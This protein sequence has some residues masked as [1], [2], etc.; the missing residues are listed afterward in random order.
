MI[1]VAWLAVR[2]DWSPLKRFL[3]G[4]VVSAVLVCLPF[5][6]LVLQP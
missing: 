3:A 1:V 2:R 4:A 6:L 5:F